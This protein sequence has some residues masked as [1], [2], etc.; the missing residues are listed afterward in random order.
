M[1]HQIQQILRSQ[2]LDYGAF[3]FYFLGT[4]HRHGLHLS[5]LVPG[6]GLTEDEPAP[7][8]LHVVAVLAALLND[9]LGLELQRGL[10]ALLEAAGEGQ[11]R[12]LLGAGP[13]AHK[14]PGQ[15]RGEGSGTRGDTTQVQERVHEG[16][17]HAP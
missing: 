8:P 3:N 9:A 4:Q 16:R 10:Q 13:R 14:G 17:H 5:L 15:E 11:Q 2:I 12:A 6:V 7:A 1:P